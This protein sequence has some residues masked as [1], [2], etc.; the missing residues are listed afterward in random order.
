MR[1]NEGAA[2]YLAVIASLSALFWA[3]RDGEWAFPL[4]TLLFPLP[5]A[6]YMARREIGRAWAF[7]GVPLLLSLAA[8]QG[9]SQTLVIAVTAFG[10]L[11]VGSGLAHGKRFKVILAEFTALVFGAGVVAVFLA[12]DAWVGWAFRAKAAA[13]QQAEGG[14]EAAHAQADMLAWL[15]E[16]WASLGFGLL[17]SLVLLLGFGLLAVAAGW[18]GHLRSEP[19]SGRRLRDVRPPDGLVWAV[20]MAGFLW[21]VDYQWPNPAVRHISWNTLAGVTAVYWLNGLLIL[22]YA[23]CA[24][25]L[26]A[27]FRTLIVIG[28]LYGGMGSALSVAG[29]FDTWLEFRQRID[30][31]AARAHG[32]SQSD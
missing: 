22:V 26:R 4:Q 32:S 17:F 20:I 12:W 15:H 2:A 9:F 11:A 5:A 10:G 16:H 6:I 28:V 13:A 25:R 29:L 23:L 14:G 7:V 1:F 21:M 24:M 27:A 31:V 3:A 18:T 19:D 8:N 30:A